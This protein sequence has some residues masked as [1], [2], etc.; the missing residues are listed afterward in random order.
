MSKINRITKSKLYTGYIFLPHFFVNAIPNSEIVVSIHKIDVTN[1]A[2]NMF[3]LNLMGL[4]QFPSTVKKTKRLT[5]VDIISI[6]GTRTERI[7]KKLRIIIFV[8][9]FIRLIVL[10]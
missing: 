2:G 3:G 4:N 1:I 8:C 9:V 7:V 6:K 10:I 5:Q